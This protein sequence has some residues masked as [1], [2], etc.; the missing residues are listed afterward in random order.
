MSIYIS[1]CVKAERSRTQMLW[2]VLFFPEW[3][4]FPW[5]KT[6]MF[7]SSTCHNPPQKNN[8]S[9]SPNQNLYSSVIIAGSRMC[10]SSISRNMSLSTRRRTTVTQLKVSQQHNRLC[11][12]FCLHFKCNFP[13]VFFLFMLRLLDLIRSLLFFF[14]SGT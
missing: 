5:M 14:H 7:H 2:S 8:H 12:Q 11:S 10:L 6:R 4:R 1:S 3:N 9:S 13:I